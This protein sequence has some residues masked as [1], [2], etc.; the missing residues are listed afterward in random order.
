MSSPWRLFL[1]ALRFCRRSPQAAA[2]DQ[3]VA[4]LGAAARY[5]P[6]ATAAIGTFGGAVYW[7]G[8]LLWPTSVAV[9]LSMLATALLSNG[10]GETIPH[11]SGGLG[12]LGSVLLVLVKY[13]ALMALS[14]A[15]LP[16][17]V[18]A[19]VALVLIM[20]CAHAAAGGMAVSLKIS[21][22]DL[23]VALA[24]GLLPAAVL[25][26]PGLIGLVAAILA[27]IA[28]GTYLKREFFAMQMLAEICFYLGA[29]GSWSYV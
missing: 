25:G 26:I 8:A 3:P 21:N 6:I 29:I 13:N 20:I 5:V 19:N 16:F 12:V 7:V 10:L 28:F 1:E 23:G 17:A 24:F 27:R 15:S 2:A 4:H 22:V 9:A 18:P 14:A 11:E